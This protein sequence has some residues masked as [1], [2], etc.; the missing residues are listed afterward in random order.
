MVEAY[1]KR[2][3]EASSLEYD[4]QVNGEEYLK[5]RDEISSLDN[6]ALIV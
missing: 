6:D 1:R 5:L 3:T 2:E 4:L